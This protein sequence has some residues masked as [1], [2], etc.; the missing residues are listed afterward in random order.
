MSRP[1]LGDY[2]KD[3]NPAGGPLKFY[4]AF[5]GTTTNPLMNAVD[6][7]R[8]NFPSVNSGGIGEGVSGKCYVGSDTSYASYAGVNEFTSTS[9]LT[10]FTIAFW[11]KK[12]PQAAGKGTD[13]VFSLNAKGYSWTN[14]K[15]FLEFEDAGNPSTT[16]LAAAK[17]YL[18]DN[19]V[20]YTNANRMP[21]VLNGSWHHLAFTYTGSSSTLKCYI[22]GQLFKTNTVG[23]VGNVTWGNF[24]GFS[25]GGPSPYTNSQN[26]WM[27]F[28]EGSLDQFRV[29][30]TALSDAD[31]QA[32]YNGKQ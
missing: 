10:A 13:F 23:T 25:I 1:L 5:D 27:T 22:D 17:F 20:E 21:N 7:T 31:I 19:W 28:M 30:T 3:A 4:V 12:T 26:T 24:D 15:L 8:A 32:L 9:P 2:P 18:M 16:A 6:S 29:Y 11:I 14:T